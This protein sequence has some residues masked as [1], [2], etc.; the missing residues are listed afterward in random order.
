MRNSEIPHRR[1]NILTG[2]WV[3]VAPKRAHRPWSQPVHRSA[4]EQ[5]AAYD[6]TCFL[7]PG[8]MRA[9][10]ERNPSYT[11]TFVFDNDFPALVSGVGSI[12]EESDSFFRRQGVSGT[13][14]VLC[15]SPCH[16]VTLAEM[17]QS[18]LIKIIDLWAN[19][20]V[21]LGKKYPWVQIFENKGLEMGCSNLHPHGQ[22]WATDHLPTE[23]LKEDR[24]QSR[25]MDETGNCMLLDYLHR[26]L[27]C[28]VRLVIEERH[29]IVVV[30]FWATWPFETLL[31]P[32]RQV[33]HIDSLDS[34]ERENLALTIGRL[35][36]SYD[37]L[38][39]TSF[40]YSMGWHGA[41]CRGVEAAH[42]QLHAHYYPP[43]FRSPSVKKFMV[44][45]EMLAE[46]QRDISPEAAAKLLR[47]ALFTNVKK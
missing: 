38:F 15:F 26:E 10:G 12:A 29:W 31:L 8:N 3:L 35:L 22:I 44:G 40:P 39:E 28:R 23:P 34:T 19:Q 46:A 5:G 7:C 21:E 30:P 14:R 24:T 4:R 2:A 41:P 27:E 16:H 9:S 18:A 45:Y 43:L 32:R 42:W 1:Y 36:A 6:P 33:A 11:D 37:N 25:Y 47:D 17:E 13:C 20:I